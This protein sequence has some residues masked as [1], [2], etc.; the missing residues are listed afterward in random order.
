MDIYTAKLDM[1]ANKI[2]TNDKL[3]NENLF[4]INAIFDQNRD[5]ITIDSVNNSKCEYLPVGMISGKLEK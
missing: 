1:I 5:D 2:C 3:V 4:E